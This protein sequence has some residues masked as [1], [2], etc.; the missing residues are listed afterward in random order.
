MFE[1][2]K[3]KRCQFGSPMAIEGIKVKIFKKIGF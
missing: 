2:K 3:K 1:K